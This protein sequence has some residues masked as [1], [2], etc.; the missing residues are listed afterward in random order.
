M[1]TF[2]SRFIFAAVFMAGA[3]L[4][5]QGASAANLPVWGGATTTQP[6]KTQQPIEPIVSQPSANTVP[7][8]Q[9][10]K[11]RSWRSP[12]TTLRPT[13]STPVQPLQT[14][15]T[16]PADT[17]TQWA[18][19]GDLAWNAT[20]TAVNTRWR[21]Q[22]T[23]QNVTINGS[24]ANGPPGCL[25]GP[26]LG[27]AIR[28][29]LLSSDVPLEVADIFAN[30]IGGAW[31]AWQD[32]VTIPGLPW[33]P[34]FA[35]WAGPAAPRTPNVPTS[36]IALVSS[37]QSELTS[38][39]RLAARIFEQFQGAPIPAETRGEIERFSGQAALKFQSW[40]AGCMV[41]RVMGQGPVPTFAPPAV[42]VGPVVGGS[43]ISSPGI[44]TGNLS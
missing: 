3:L 37:S 31:K 36:L 43:V 16:G 24:T 17:K 23:I 19:W 44:I 32:S 25:Q 39:G 33:Y 34:V 7:T 12:G 2:T 6:Q 22:A 15:T 10:V 5:G 4:G 14:R 21:L 27:P 9:P 13:V 40:M 1:G 41:Q 29:H 11:P 18:Q 42:P 26:D 35:A 28:S 20:K 38:Q 8:V 30:G